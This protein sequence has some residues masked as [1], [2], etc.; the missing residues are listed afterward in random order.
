MSFTEFLEN[1]IDQ[2]TSEIQLGMVCQIEKFNADT[3]RADVKPL[4]KLENELTQT[5]DFPII[6]E[7][8]V[9]F[10]HGD[11]FAIKPSYVKGDLVWVG[12]STHDIED[13]LKEY[14]R[15]ASKKTFEM[16]NACVLGGIVK[17][18]FSFGSLYMIRKESDHIA[19]GIK[20]GAVEPVVKAETFDN[21]FTTFIDALKNI[22]VGG[23]SS[24][25]LAAIVTA[26]TTISTQIGTWDSTDT[27]VS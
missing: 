14:S 5:A 3:M 9:L 15:I 17:D 24:A 25:G 1:I 16:H 26:A 19:I 8:P 20:D 21:A 4:L 13:A 7:I 11:N 27:K 6:T 22:P 12:F 2:K 18:D 23:S 10:Y